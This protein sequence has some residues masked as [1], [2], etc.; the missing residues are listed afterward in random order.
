MWT[1][2]TLTITLSPLQARLPDQIDKEALAKAQREEFPDYWQR[3]QDE[4]DEEYNVQEGILFSCR[5]PGPRQAR[6]PRVLLPRAWRQQVVDRCHKQTGHSGRWIT[7]RSVQEAYVWPGMRKDVNTQLQ[8]CAIC[9]VHKSHPEKV[10]HTMMPDP[11]YP[12]Q[13]VS[14]DITGPFVRSK[15]GHTYLLTFI[16]HLTGFADAYAIGNKRG[17]TVASILH[18]DYIPRY[19]PPEMILSD[20][21][22][23]FVNSAVAGI[24][25]AHGVEHRHTTPYHPRTNGLIERW[26]RTLKGIMGRLMAV[27]NSSWEEQ[28]GPALAAYRSS[29]SS[30]RGMTPFQALYGREMRIPTA[31]ALHNPHQTEI[32]G[33]DRLASLVNTWACARESLRS[34]REANAAIQAKKRLSQPLLVGDNVILLRPGMKAAFNPGWAGRWQIIRARDPVYW[35]HH[36]PTGEQKV[37]NRDKLRYVPPGID[38]STAPDGGNH[39]DPPGQGYVLPMP[40]QEVSS[41]LPIHPSVEDADAYPGGDPQHS[42]SPPSSEGM[43]SN[44]GSRLDGAD[45][46]VDLTT[47]TSA[48]PSSIRGGSTSD[49]S[50]DVPSSMGGVAGPGSNRSTP[51]PV[52]GSTPEPSSISADTPPPPPIPRRNPPRKRHPP[53]YYGWDWNPFITKRGRFAPV[54]WLEYAHYSY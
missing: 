5:R 21:G 6:Y 20:N 12:H 43:R 53:V 2:W 40:L 38:W 19:G 47:G 8:H 22:T 23:E 15:K 1:L 42:T 17:D 41:P 9:Q 31:V 25:R 36:V 18:Q 3:A 35:I 27:N 50:S 39:L 49:M 7:F 48:G 24:L 30:S 28:L 52:N 54:E 14:V 16:D 32:F 13:Y 11:V 44:V 10:R 26:H 37:V 29:A 45:S 4:D 34:Q 46:D 51:E 33:D